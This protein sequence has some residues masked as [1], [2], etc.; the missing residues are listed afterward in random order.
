MKR[1]VL[2]L[3]V[4]SML[5]FHLSGCTGADQK[6]TRR[7][8]ELDDSNYWKYLAVSADPSELAE[9]ETETVLT[10]AVRGVLDYAYYEDVVVTFEVRYRE[11]RAGGSRP[12]DIKS[13]EVKVK[14]NAAGDAEFIVDYTGAAAE[15]NGVGDA[16]AEHPAE[17]FWFYRNLWFKSV[18]GKV[19]FTA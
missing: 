14:L 17:L 4:V 2:F 16:F 12:S 10:G 18:S 8:V 15:V 13:Y 3:L 6:Q 7:V 9:A 1:T 11:E 5:L 19:I